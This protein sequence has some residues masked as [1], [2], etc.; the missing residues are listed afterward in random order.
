MA[1]FTPKGNQIKFHV[2]VDQSSIEVFVND[3]ALVMTSLVFPYS[4]G[5]GI[6][7]FSLNGKTTTMISLKI[8]ELAS[9]WGID[10]PGAITGIE[11]K[12]EIAL[13]VY[14]NPASVNEEVRIQVPATSSVVDVTLI[15]LHGKKT[16]HG[17]DWTVD[18]G[19]VAIR[20]IS[21]RGLYVIRVQ[22]R[23]KTIYQKLIVN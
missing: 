3:G 8:W 11:K 12:D 22:Q 21:Q 15:D 19:I 4:N 18:E 20:G 6:E 23:D 17:I 16:H 10:P 14:P 2:F 7:T 5:L 9:I 1:P 13:N